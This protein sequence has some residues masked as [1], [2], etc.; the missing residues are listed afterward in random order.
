VGNAATT[1]IQLLGGGADGNFTNISVSSVATFGAGTVSAPSITTT[2]DTN[3]GIFFPAAD[4][5]A[6]TEGGVESMRIDSSARV[7]I[8]GSDPSVGNGQMVVNQIANNGIVVNQTASGSGAVLYLRNMTDSTINSLSF[9]NTGVRF[10]DAGIGSERMRID[11]SGNVGIGTSSP[12][13]YGKFVVNGSANADAGIFIGNSSLTGSAPTY[14]GTVRIID[15]PTSSTG[16]SGGLEFLTSTFGSG[17]GWKIAAIDSSGVPLTFATRQNSASWTE[18]MR[19]DTSGNVIIG[20]TTTNNKFRVYLNSSAVGNLSSANF[21]QDGAGDAALSFLIGATTE[22]LVG[23]DNSDSD[24]FKISNITGVGDFTATGLTIT[25]AGN[26]S[27]SGSLSKGS[28]SFRIDHPLPQLTETHQLVHSFVEAPKADLIY[29][30]RVTLV[31]GKAIVNID[32][33]ATMTEGTFE[34]LCCDVQCFTTNESDWTPVR[35]SVTGNILTI[36]SQD[37][38]AKSDIS[39]MVIGERKDKHM[40]DTDWTDDNGKVIVEPL[41]EIA[42]LESK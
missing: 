11:S 33:T 24:K 8:N 10:F 2:G 38:L 30:G 20:T 18:A 3:T 42:A 39:W 7:S 29:R 12:S 26:V 41:K 15:N 32:E 21:T 14:K 1:P 22:W 5:I 23:V 4:T 16:T 13:T 25:T 35:G 37:A 34:V 17:Y 27:I 40:M 36:E 6:F 19:I 9:T 31:N 28:G